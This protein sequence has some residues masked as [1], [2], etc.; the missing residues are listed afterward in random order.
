MQ[1]NSVD[2]ATNKA[3]TSCL[4]ALNWQTRCSPSRRSASSSDFWWW[5]GDCLGGRLR[6]EHLGGTSWPRAPADPEPL[7]RAWRW[8]LPRRCCL[9]SG[10]QTWEVWLPASWQTTRSWSGSRFSRSRFESRSRSGSLVVVVAAVVVVAVVWP[11]LCKTR[12]SRR[13]HWPPSPCTRPQW[14]DLSS[15]WQSWWKKIRQDS[16]FKLKKLC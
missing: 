1:P 4:K 16:N 5:S 9:E 3:A 10:S 12:R 7:R 14:P 13:T 11:W 2:D 8:S 15:W 6:P